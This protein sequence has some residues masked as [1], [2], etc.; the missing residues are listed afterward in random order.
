MKHKRQILFILILSAI[1]WSCTKQENKIYIEGNTPPVLTSSVTNGG[2]IPL[3]FANKDQEAIK[4]SWTNP[5]YKFTTGNS[6][7]N[8]SYIVDI[9]TTGSNF[10]NPQRKTITI[11]NDQSLSISQN[12]LNDYLLNTLRLDSAVVHNIEI[13]VTA[14]LAGGTVPVASNVLKF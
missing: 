10:T 1:V 9:D 7:Q 11:S 8:V 3:S 4:L 13:R 6:S 5:N 12:D 14:S 2:T